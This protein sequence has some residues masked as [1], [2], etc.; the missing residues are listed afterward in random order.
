MTFAQACARRIPADVRH[1]L[2][3]PAD[4][5]THAQPHPRN[6]MMMQLYDIWN[7][8]IEP[9]HPNNRHCLTC[10]HHILKN[11]RVMKGYLVE[12]EGLQ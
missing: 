1:A 10:L 11:F 6:A 12:A 9:Q 5:I 4:P 7:A 2:L 8:Y 3:A